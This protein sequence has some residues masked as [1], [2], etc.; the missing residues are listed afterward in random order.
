M[1]YYSAIKREEHNKM[2][3]FQKHYT[4]QKKPDIRVYKSMISN[5][6]NSRINKTNLY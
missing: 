5:I 2:D 6:Y 1:E 3:E 4:E